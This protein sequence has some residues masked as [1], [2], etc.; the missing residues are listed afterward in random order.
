VAAT[1]KLLYSASGEPVKIAFG[2]I[3]SNAGGLIFGTVIGHFTAAY[4]SW[5][6]FILHEPKALRQLSKKRMKE[7]AGEH[8]DYPR[9]AVVGGVLNNLAQWAHVAVFIFFYG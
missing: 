8:R 2:L 5:K 7:L 3:K 9:Y 6:K 4:Y 1:S